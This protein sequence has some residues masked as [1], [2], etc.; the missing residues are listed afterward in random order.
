MS[1][2]ESPQLT[3]QEFKANGEYSRHGPQET[4]G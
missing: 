2:V 4:Y 3:F 1:S